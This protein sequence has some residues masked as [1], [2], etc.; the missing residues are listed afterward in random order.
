M[1][2]SWVA[3]TAGTLILA[4][5]FGLAGFA[6]RRHTAKPSA[7]AATPPLAY[8]IAAAR[9][10][11]PPPP[12]QEQT[13][14]ERAPIAGLNL[15]RTSSDESG[16][17]APADRGVARLT[18]DADLQRTTLALMRSRHVPEAAVVLMDVATGRLLIYASH[19]DRGPARDLC[20]EATAP[21]ASLFK[22]VTASALVEDAHLGPD[23]KECYSGGEQRIGALDLVP[24]AQRDRWCTTLAGALGRS[25]NTVFARLAAEHLAP[26][27]L[28]AM[29]RRLVYG[30]ELSFDVPVQTSAVHMP[31]TPLE[32]ARTAAGFWNTTLS[33]LAA[34]EM[35]AIVARGGE[36][37]RPSIVESIASESGAVIWSAPD[38]P[39]PRRA[40]ARDTAEQVA[41]MMAHT[42]NEGTSYRAFHDPHGTPFLPGITVAGKTGTLTSSDTRRFYTWFTGFA[43][44]AAQSGAQVA[45][46][47][48]VINGPEW[49]V[50]ANVLAREVLR[51]YFAARGATGVTRPNT[52]AVARRRREK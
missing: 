30:Q 36:T 43:P 6:R 42:V 40:I 26:S 33:P 2:R 3:A 15:L 48:L 22:I 13:G 24:D 16:V 10:T 8:A 4:A 45:V 35:S 29:A 11:A 49:Q 41:A 17:V 21:S 52:T 28:E 18:L 19:I 46:A 50:K 27:Q 38:P 34:A 37:V 14:G 39:A 12:A 44:I 20:V 25:I 5:A 31:S 47:A 51:A 32:F 9:E 1:R 7:T 23:T